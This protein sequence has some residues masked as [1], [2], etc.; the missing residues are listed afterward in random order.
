MGLVMGSP[1][2]TNSSFLRFYA[3]TVKFTDA[4]WKSCNESIAEVLISNC[5]VHNKYTNGAACSSMSIFCFYLHPSLSQ[6]S[7][8]LYFPIEG[9]RWSC[10]APEGTLPPTG[11]RWHCWLD[12]RPRAY[13]RRETAMPKHSPGEARTCPAVRRCT[14]LR[15]FN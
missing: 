9:S 3:R 12:R 5:P 7:A 2:R 4:K 6:P 10:Q 11:S 15:V 1:G 8:S 14:V 13:P